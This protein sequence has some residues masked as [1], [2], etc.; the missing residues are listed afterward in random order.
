MCQQHAAD[1][2]QVVGLLRDVWQTVGLDVYVFPYGVLPTKYECG[3]IQARPSA[4]GCEQHDMITIF[5][6]S[7]FTPLSPLAYAYPAPAQGGVGDL[8]SALMKT[9]EG[10]DQWRQGSDH[11]INMSVQCM[12]LQC[13]PNTTSRASMGETADG[14]LYDV[15][16]RDYGAPGSP[17]FEAARLN[18]I[19]SCAG[20][21]AT[22]AHFP[23]ELGVQLLHVT[24]HC[25]TN[26]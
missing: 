9:S 24:S 3:I 14:G 15:F 22:V 18:F 1:D 26:E 4:S 19:R 10:M 21:A 11:K 17:R 23:L 20:W 7:M 13:V 5:P 6:N 2:P 12:P 8:W 16:R 25:C